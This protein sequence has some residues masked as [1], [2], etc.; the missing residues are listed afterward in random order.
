MAVVSTDH[1]G[2]N[3]VA[4]K[5]M[6]HPGGPTK[7]TVLV[8]EHV[9]VVRMLLAN[10][11]RR[12]GFHVVEA[13]NGEEAIRVVE[14]GRPVQLVLS[15]V[16]MPGAGRDGLNLARWLHQH[17]PDLKVI[18]ASGGISTLDPADARF[19]EGL[20]LQKPFKLEELAQRPRSALG[21]KPAGAAL[22]I[23]RRR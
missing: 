14:A 19:H 16:H 11:L 1:R 4:A 8:V 23:G 20:L 13:A 10:L 22:P 2:I 5:R 9:P 12:Y 3:M 21:D 15:D 6:D 7:P 17:R 18:L